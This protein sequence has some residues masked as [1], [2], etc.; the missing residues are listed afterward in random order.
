MYIGDVDDI[1]HFIFFLMIRR[2]PRSTRTD[3]LFP[4]T[5]LF[6]SASD[7]IRVRGA[8]ALR[9]RPASQCRED[10]L[11]SLGV[12]A[13][14]AVVV[15]GWVLRRT[16]GRVVC[17]V[18]PGLP[19]DVTGAPRSRIG[20]VGRQGPSRQSSGAGD[21]CSECGGDARPGGQPEAQQG[22]KI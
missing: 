3:T 14:A 16:A 11:R 8:L 21:V 17:R 18:R 9:V 13:S 2:P 15:E 4:Y 19:V 6:R 22:E 10:R 20:A 7:R 5:T 1:V 12:Q